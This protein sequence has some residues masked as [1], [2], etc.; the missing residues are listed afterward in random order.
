MPHVP[1]LDEKHRQTTKR[2][3]GLPPPILPHTIS[4][5]SLRMRENYLFIRKSI[6]DD[7][8]IDVLGITR[9]R[10]PLLRVLRTKLIDAKTLFLL[11]RDAPPLNSFSRSIDQIQSEPNLDNKNASWQMNIF[12]LDF[13]CDFLWKEKKNSEIFYCFRKKSF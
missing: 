3:E 10:T 8:L 11:A 4:W 7:T 6:K 2:Y 5:P 9:G 13:G 12:A 1:S